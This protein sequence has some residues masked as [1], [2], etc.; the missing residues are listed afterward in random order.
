MTFWQKTA[1]W[2]GHRLNPALPAP[3]D[4]WWYG[5]VAHH[6]ASGLRVT[7]RTSLQSAAMWAC[8]RVISETV[9]T[10]PFSVYRRLEPRGKEVATDHAAHY[11]LHDAPNEEITSVEFWEVI[12]AHALTFGNGFA[13][14]EWDSKM[15]PAGLYLMQPE[16]VT[17]ERDRQTAVKF[18]RYR[19]PG[20]EEVILFDDEVLHIPGLGYD[21]LTGYSPVTLHRRTLELAQSTDEYLLK[22][23]TNNARP[24]MY[25]SHPGKLS[26]AAAKNIRESWA[27]IHAGLQNA[28][29]PGVLEEGMRVETVG[30]IAKDMEFLAMR[31]FQT[32]EIARIYRVP[33]HMIQSLDRSTNNNIEHQSIDFVMHTIRPWCR[34]IEARANRTLFGPRE[35]KW[36][37]SEF[38]LEGLL[39]GDSKGRAEFYASLRNIGAITANE[40][41]E[42]ENMNPIEGGDALLVQGAMIPIDQAGQ[43]AQ[44]VPNA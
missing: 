4:D 8:V 15:S 14:I 34:R 24:G 17:V 32:E 10:L 38:N 40:I 11:L 13:R 1:A 20:K 37:F 19:A 16:W 3:D 30:S 44:G 33:L 2:I 9:A 39:R 41:R 7:P 28:G 5:P 43:Q 36:Y 22:F 35:G 29:K 42:K 21:G 31:K 26:D 6:G 27:A 18:Y 25:I 23:L 12:V